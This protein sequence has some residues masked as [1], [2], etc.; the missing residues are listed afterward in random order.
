[1]LRRPVVTVR[2][3]HQRIVVADQHGAPAV[4]VALA[5]GDAAYTTGPGGLV[6]LG[7]AATPG[8]FMRVQGIPAG[9]IPDRT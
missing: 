9:R 1:V 2:E 7:Q 4:G 5:I 3:D 8:T 6:E